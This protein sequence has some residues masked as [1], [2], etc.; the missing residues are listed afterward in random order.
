MRFIVSIPLALILAAAAQD[1][2]DGDGILRCS[3]ETSTLAINSS[4]LMEKRQNQA[5]QP[6]SIDLYMHFVAPD[7]GAPKKLVRCDLSC[8]RRNT[9]PVAA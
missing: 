5:L 9:H 1:S 6:I 2:L 4:S 3:T 7:N 8:C